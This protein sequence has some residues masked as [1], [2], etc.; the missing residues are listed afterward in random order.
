[1]AP[2]KTE[3]RFD[4]V[5]QN[6][7]DKLLPRF[8]AADDELKQQIA[9]EYG[10]AEPQGLKRA[11]SAGPTPVAD[12]TVEPS[13]KRQ[14]FGDEKLSVERKR[15]TLQR[16][17]CSHESL[18]L[19]LRVFSAFSSSFSGHEK[20]MIFELRP[21]VPPPSMS[22]AGTPSPAVAAP[23]PPLAYPF[24]NTSAKVTVKYL[25][26]FIAERLG[27]PTTASPL[28]IQCSGEVLGADHSIEFVWRTR[29]HHLHPNQ[30]LVL[31]YRLQSHVI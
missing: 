20:L 19:T 14:R 10:K 5:M 15:E 16:Y 9:R 18:M 21:Y 7:V 12:G 27:M 2:M 11:N 29:W 30:H 25:R 8:H 22:D 24:V 6:L 1:M 31:T 23:L 13:S 28:D 26:K 4:R 3:I 17:S